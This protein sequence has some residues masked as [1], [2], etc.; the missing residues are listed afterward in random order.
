MAIPLRKVTDI[1]KLRTA[2]LAVAKTLQYLE[3]NVISGMTLLEVDKM[4]E[5]FLRNLGARPAF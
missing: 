3:Q 4:G 2:G 5:D 1:Q